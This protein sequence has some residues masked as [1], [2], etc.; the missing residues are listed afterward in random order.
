M[1]K[2]MVDPVIS[3]SITDSMPRLQ[4]RND[5]H[6]KISEQHNYMPNL[7]NDLFFVGI[8]KPVACTTSPTRMSSLGP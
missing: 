3:Y 6:N 5:I 1:Y 4:S 7:S 8:L 2:A